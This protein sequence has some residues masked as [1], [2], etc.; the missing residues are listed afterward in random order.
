MEAIEEGR[1]EVPLQ[2]RGAYSK[3]PP[4]E[5]IDTQQCVIQG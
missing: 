1:A 4:F 2:S 5:S 3:G